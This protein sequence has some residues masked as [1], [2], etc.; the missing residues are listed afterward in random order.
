[1]LLFYS[2][3][4]IAA[5]IGG[6][7]S[8]MQECASRAGDAPTSAKTDEQWG[9]TAGLHS[10]QEITPLSRGLK[11]QC[12][13]PSPGERPQMT[14]AVRTVGAAAGRNAQQVQHLVLHLLSILASKNYAVP[15][16][17]FHP[18]AGTADTDTRVACSSSSYDGYFPGLAFRI[19]TRHEWK[20]L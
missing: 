18:A 2:S 11:D 10:P 9:A 5:L 15:T 20:S 16:R 3:E 19:I 8:S 17:L 4:L 14:S 7:I 12:I 6:K 13:I 1:M